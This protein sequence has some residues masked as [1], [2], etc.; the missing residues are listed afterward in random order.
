MPLDKIQQHQR[1]QRHWHQRHRHHQ[2][3]RQRHQRHRHHQH[4]RQRHWHHRHHRHHRHQRHR[5]KR[6]RHQ[7]VPFL[8][9][10]FVV[11]RVR[12][13]T[14]L[15]LFPNLNPVSLFGIILHAP[16]SNIC[17]ISCSKCCIILK[18]VNNYSSLHV[19]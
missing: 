3:Q 5:H 14:L 19:M 4:Q 17:C 13:L 15:H 9:F 7:R 1:H 18:P 10:V 11:I 8:A 16:S 12:S 2:H 6:H